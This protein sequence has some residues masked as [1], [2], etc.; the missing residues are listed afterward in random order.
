ML[1]NTR[2]DLLTLFMDADRFRT[3]TTLARTTTSDSDL[4]NHKLH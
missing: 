1:L 2:H 3:Y 4:E